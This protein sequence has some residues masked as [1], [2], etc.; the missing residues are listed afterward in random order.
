MSNP[1][2]EDELA[3]AVRILEG[4]LIFSQTKKHMNRTQ[5][6]EVQALLDQQ[7]EHFLRR[8]EPES[9]YYERFGDH[10]EFEGQT[11]IEI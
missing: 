7:I 3:E 5:R 11:V 4:V 6:N 2:V 10:T 9:A 8:D 1:I